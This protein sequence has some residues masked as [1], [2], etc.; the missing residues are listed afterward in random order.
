MTDGKSLND[1]VSDAGN[2][3]KELFISKNEREYRKFVADKEHRALVTNT[4]RQLSSDVEDMRL[5]KQMFI[6]QLDFHKTADIP[7]SIWTAVKNSMNPNGAMALAALF[8]GASVLKT[9]EPELRA[10]ATKEFEEIEFKFARFQS[11]NS[12]LLH[13]LGLIK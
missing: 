1:M 4:Y 2:A 11:E 13:E 8:A 5:K 3:L 6:Q 9:F 12:K 7:L 10:L